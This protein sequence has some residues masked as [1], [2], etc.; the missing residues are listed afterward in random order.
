MTAL[1]E[2]HSISGT[3]PAPVPPDRDDGQSDRPEA[4]L[5]PR[6]MC[7]SPSGMRMWSSTY[8]GAA[9]RPPPGYEPDPGRSAGGSRLSQLDEVAHP[10][11][12]RRPTRCRP[13]SRWR[14]R[15]TARV[16]RCWPLDELEAV[17]G[18]ARAL[19]LAVHLDGA[20]LFFNAAVPRGHRPAAIAARFDTVTAVLWKELG[21]PLGRC[22]PDQVERAWREKLGAVRQAGIVAAAGVYALDHHRPSG[23]RPRKGSAAGRAWA[24]AAGRSRA[25]RD[26]FRAG[27]RRQ[28]R[29]RARR[30][31][32]SPARAV[33]GFQRPFIRR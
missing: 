27:G 25:G 29:A 24:G 9:P 19:G 23:R 30:G 4:A 26:E 14:T 21:C 33:S 18:T 28:A 6:G 17:V 10:T 1:Q 12:R 32:R 7:S 3:K 2:R 20:R 13:C 16:G 11:A 5:A 31:A 22:W 8:G 15:T